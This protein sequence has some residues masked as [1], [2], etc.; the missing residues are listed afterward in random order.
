M[1]KLYFGYFVDIC[2]IQVSR[3]CFAITEASAIEKILSSP[4][5]IG[6]WLYGKCGIV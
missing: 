6:F 5:I 2:I 4:F 3:V 1:S